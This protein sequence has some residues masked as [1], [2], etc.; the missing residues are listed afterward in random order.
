MRHEELSVPG[1]M[2]SGRAFAVEAIGAD[3]MT[4][5]EAINI[6]REFAAEK[7][8]PW[9]PP[10]KTERKEVGPINDVYVIRTHDTWYGMNVIITVD[11][12]SG[13]VVKGIYLPR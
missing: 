5:N 1:P 11:M 10:I 2:I 8:W 6:A 9:L 13:H 3:R 12:A 4:E 7:G